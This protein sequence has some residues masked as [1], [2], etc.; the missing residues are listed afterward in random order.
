[1]ITKHERCGNGKPGNNAWYCC[2]RRKGH[3]GACVYRV[4]PHLWNAYRT[5][6]I[7]HLATGVSK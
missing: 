1:M 2:L 6:Q 4:R 5:A 7:I 3:Q